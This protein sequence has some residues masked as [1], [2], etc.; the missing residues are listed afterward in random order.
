MR[1]HPRVLSPAQHAAARRL[2]PVMR[3]RGF[4]L[5]G[6]TA[7]ALQLGH[8]RSVDL[9]W[10]TPEPMPDPLLLA[11]ALQEQVDLR[12]ES[13][14]RGTLHGTT[15]S[16][17]ASFLEYRYPLLAPLA[18]WAPASVSIASLDDIAAMKLAAV[19][20]RGS[21]KDFVDVYALGRRL[22]LARMLDLYARKYEIED[23]GHVLFALTYFD[24]A[25]RERMPVLLR[26][27]SWPAIK[28]RIRGLVRGLTG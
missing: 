28:Q 19:A 25:D 12:V 18:E 24:D 13:T 3:E 8:R 17:R 5:A 7:L 15:A 22:T 10:F 4:Y 2:G 21:K 27:W 9:D 11:R 26:E 23:Y 1:F 16:V 14:E 20:Q 6:G